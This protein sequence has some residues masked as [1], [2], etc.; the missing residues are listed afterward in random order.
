MTLIIKNNIFIG[1]LLIFIGIIAII[2][3]TFG[4]DLFYIPYVW[5]IFLVISGLS[6]EMSYLNYRKDLISGFT[7]SIFLIYGLCTFILNIFNIVPRELNL[8]IIY[9]EKYI[10]FVICLGLAAAYSQTYI[11]SIR[12]SK[13]LLRAILFIC[14]CIINIL[15]I[16]Y[17]K[18]FMN[19]IIL[20]IIFGSGIYIIYVHFKYK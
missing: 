16:K 11:F 20:S 3:K 1:S 9:P 2:I 4:I 10:L 14:I 18:F 5:P 17:N 6:L 8:S 19:I 12:N 13:Y 7:G 15:F